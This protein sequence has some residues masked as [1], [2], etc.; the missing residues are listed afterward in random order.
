MDAPSAL[1]PRDSNGLVGWIDDPDGRGTAGILWSCILT[2]T[3]CVWSALHLNIPPKHDTQL[4]YWLRVTRWVLIGVLAPELVLWAA[5]RQ[6]HSARVLTNEMQ[7]ILNVEEQQDRPY[8]GDE[9]G[10]PRLERKDSRPHTRR[11]KWTRLHS[12]YV[13]M[14]G[15]VIDMVESTDDEISYIPRYRRLTLS[16]YAAVLLAKCGHLPDLDPDDIKDKSKAD[17]L[18]KVIVLLQ[19]GWFLLQTIARIAQHLPVSLLE[20]NTIGHVVCAL[21]IY[22]LWWN[23]PRE[24]REPTVLEGPWVRPLCAFMFMSSRI[25]GVQYRTGIRPSA[26]ITPE[27]ENLTY[28]APEETRPS[29]VP[30]PDRERSSHGIAVYS[31]HAD[32][33]TKVSNTPP[34]VGGD[35]T[36]VSEAQ[37]KQS[38]PVS[39]LDVESRAH[40][41]TRS[42]FGDFRTEIRRQDTANTAARK[43]KLGWAVE[44]NDDDATSRLR[45]LRH[46]LCAEAFQSYPAVREY[47]VRKTPSSSEYVPQLEQFLVPIAINWPSDF[48]MRGLPTAFV[49][50]ILWFVSI[51]YGCIHLA[52]WNE[53]FPSE[54]ERL[55][56]HMSAGYICASGVWWTTAHVLFYIWPWLRNWWERFTHLQSNWLQ[57]IVYGFLMSCAGTLYI[58]TRLYLPVEGLVALR[59]APRSMYD[60]VDWA[61]FIPHF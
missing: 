51:L 23:K 14:G 27:L 29:S 36:E 20:V 13:S 5:W 44:G 38:R 54:T 18:A 2:L 32:E 55:L 46:E 24:V 49:G 16:P 61:K 15:F 43:R 21:F 8:G 39:F 41:T 53:F 4:S 56:W 17:S 26:W 42:E 7:Q 33:V 35:A 47:F 59:S 9:K 37:D 6:W 60:T 31:E 30:T 11:H 1:S 22:V 50:I 57:Y 19:A 58:L 12:F 52:A 34:S 3:L 25:S 10:Q 48:L 28:V 40:A 45:A